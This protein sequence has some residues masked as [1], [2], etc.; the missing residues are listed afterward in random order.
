[1]DFRYEIRP[2]T[3]ANARMSIFN[4]RYEI[5]HARMRISPW[6][7]FGVDFISDDKNDL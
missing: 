7:F 4:T 1:M 2:A 6:V 3:F 5:D